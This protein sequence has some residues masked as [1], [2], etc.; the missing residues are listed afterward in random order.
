MKP[1]AVGPAYGSALARGRAQRLFGSDGCG[2]AAFQDRSRRSSTAAMST[3]GKSADGIASE[4]LCDYVFWC[5]WLA[6]RGIK[7]VITQ[8]L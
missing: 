7:T 6:V 4:A 5:A 2:L 3:K 8:I 1:V